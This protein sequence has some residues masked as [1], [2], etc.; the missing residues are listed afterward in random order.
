MTCPG[1]LKLS[2]APYYR[3]LAVPVGERELAQAHLANALFDAHR[4]D[5]EFGHRLLA[6]E[7]ARA[8]LVAC[9][10]TV[11]RIYLANGR[12]SV[13]GKKR[14]RG[15]KKAGPPAHD[16]PVLRHF[17]ADAA[18]PAMALGHHRAPHEPGQGLPVRDQGRVLQPDRRLL[19]Q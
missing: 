15:G 2:R 14:T 8:G 4:D 16:D 9:D 1:L 12:W 10:R 6:D 13:F 17:T 19:D 11:W 5:P 7:A 18:E 3:W